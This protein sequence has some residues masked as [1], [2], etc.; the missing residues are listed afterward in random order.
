MDSRGKLPPR[1]R[2]AR[3]NRFAG[4]APRPLPAA[5]R[6]P[7]SEVSG[8][9]PQPQATASFSVSR[10]P[11]LEV[12]GW[13]PNKH[14]APQS[15]TAAGSKASSGPGGLFGEKKSEHEPPK[16]WG[17]TVR[18]RGSR[19]QSGAPLGSVLCKRQ[20]NRRRD[21]TRRSRKSL[22]PS[23]SPRVCAGPGRT[24]RPC[25]RD[26]GDRLQREAA[27]R[28]EASTPGRFPADSAQGTETCGRNSRSKPRLV[29]ASQPGKGDRVGAR[30]S[31]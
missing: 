2:A 22:R 14:C 26:A 29:V 17:R 19:A 12:R 30:R 11:R 8:G 28:T 15:R 6:S 21:P 7:V 20:R 31:P 9:Q 5:P 3:G 13:S 25:P 18:R 23:S 24:S 1:R 4:R 10:R 27:P 16:R